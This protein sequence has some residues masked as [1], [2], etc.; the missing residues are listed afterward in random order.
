MNGRH[1]QTANR[2]AVLAVKIINGGNRG[3]GNE[4]KFS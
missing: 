1:G 3:N 2:N 4:V